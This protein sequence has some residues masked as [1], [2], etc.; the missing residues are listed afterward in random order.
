MMNKVILIIVAI[1]LLFGCFFATKSYSQTTSTPY[2]YYSTGKLTWEHPI[3]GGT[4]AGYI[5]YYGL[6]SGVYTYTY[7]VVGENV[8]EVLISVLP[9]IVL[10]TT[11][12]FAVKAYNAAGESELSNEVY[13]IPTDEIKKTN[14]L[15]LV[16][17]T[18]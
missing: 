9:D 2:I 18:S 17:P 1:V 8:L 12:Y 6:Q 13:G 16:V 4:P 7:T 5:V 10:E 15:I 14:N 11:Y 3:D